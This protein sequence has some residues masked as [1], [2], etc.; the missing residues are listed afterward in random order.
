VLHDLASNLQNQGLY[1]EALEAWRALEAEMQSHS[2][3]SMGR[4]GI[5]FHRGFCAE[6]SELL[7]EAIESYS[8]A[9]QLA[10][11]QKEEVG[12]RKHLG[13]LLFNRGEFQGALK[14]LEALSILAPE[15]GEVHYFFG[16]T[17]STMGDFERAERHLIYARRLAPKDARVDAKLGAL[18]LQQKQFSK[19]L[20]Y[21]NESVAKNPKAHEPWYSLRAVYAMMDD[22]E[23]TERAALTYK[24]LRD[25]ATVLEEISRSN[26][27]RKS[28]NPRDSEAYFNQATIFFQNGQITEGMTELMGLL[29]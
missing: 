11:G 8:R 17:L 19:A 5:P 13:V 18:Y 29:V 28:V 1:N 14:Q 2:A 20:T 25:N 4:H 9:V 3:E 27:R 23:Q 7:P 16:A 6:K 15:D 21:L 22:S 26:R 24:E 12:Y 10:I